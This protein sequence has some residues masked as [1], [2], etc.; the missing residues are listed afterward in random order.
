[1]GGGDCTYNIYIYRP[2]GC[3]GLYVP[4]LY[5][6]HIEVTCT[7]FHG[8]V[9]RQLELV[10]SMLSVGVSVLLE[11]ESVFLIQKKNMSGCSTGMHVFLSNNETCHLVEQG[12]ISSCRTAGHAILS[13]KNTCFL[14]QQD[15]MSSCST[16]QRG[17]I[18]SCSTRRNVLLLERKTPPFAEHTNFLLSTNVV[19]TLYLFL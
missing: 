1:M 3:P 6:G 14:V 10:V 2:R 15:D 16:T 18:P 12:F 13:N 7:A 19:P 9:G 8:S 5:L 17:H 4:Y 11:A